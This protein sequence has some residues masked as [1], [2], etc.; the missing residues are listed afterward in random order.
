MHP[1]RASIEEPLL[2]PSSSTSTFAEP[3][4]PSIDDTNHTHLGD[5]P[6]NHEPPST[7]VQPGVL[8]IEATTRAWTKHSLTTAY[9][10]IYLIYFVETLLAGTTAALVPYVTS[11]FSMHSL[12]PTVSI[13]SN[14]VGGVTNL[15]IAK[16]IDVFGRPHGFILCVILGTIGLLLMTV[17]EGVGTYAAAMI[18]HTVGNN[19]VQYILSVFIADTTRLENRA[20]MQALMNSTGLIT[21]WVAGPLAQRYLNGLGWRWA[22]GMFGALVP[23]V[24][25]P[26]LGLLVWNYRKAKRMGVMRERS[27]GRS[28]A[29]SV[30]HYCREFDAIGLCLVSVGVT[31]FLLPFNLHTLAGNGWASPSMVG[32]SILGVFFLVAFAFWE[33]NRAMIPLL[34]YSLLMDR[35]VFGACLLCTCLFGSYAVWNSYFGSYLQVVQGLSVEEASY[36]AQAYTVVSVLFAVLTGYIIHRTG[37][38]K[39]VSLVIGIPL[40]MLG[41]G[42]MVLF[43]APGNT[44]YIIVCFLLISVSQGVLVVTDEMAILAAG[45]HEHVAAMLALVSIF[46]NIGGAIGLTIAAS[47]WSDVL[48]SR[49]RQYLPT[50]ELP[51]LHKI[52]GDLAKQLSYPIGSPTHIAIQHAYE[53]AMSRLLLV[54]TGIWLLGAVGVLMW[55]NI[56]VKRIQQSKGH[57]W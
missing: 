32:M 11:A 16:I 43:L 38:F 13:L 36:V 40:S 54:S 47:I 39:T 55:R 18:F 56:N 52:F 35:T 9:A 14:V 15:T 7:T 31:L 44:A 48:P 34:P 8:A 45:S 20:L 5:P 51:D 22:F 49:L 30:V 57:V 17:C 41:Q 2:S 37:R 53:D 24:T 1:S 21:G 23:L 50:E 27:N 12:T 10:M 6:A 4:K 19:G 46:G 33:R 26:L 42:L 25:L 3:T 29:Q 28:A